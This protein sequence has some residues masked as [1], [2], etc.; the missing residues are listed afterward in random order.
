MCLTMVWPFDGG[1]FK[2]CVD[3]FD[4]TVCVLRMLFRKQVGWCN[5]RSSFFRVVRPCCVLPGDSDLTGISMLG[6]MSVRSAE[7]TDGII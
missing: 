4:S 1:G 6:Q 7:M 3:V 2:W 5:G